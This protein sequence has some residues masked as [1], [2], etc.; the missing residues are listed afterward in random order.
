MKERILQTLSDLRKYA[1]DKGYEVIAFL[2][3]RRQLPDAFRQLV[4]L[5]EHQRAFDP[6]G[7]HRLFR[8]ETRQL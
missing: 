2:P 1:L 7:D 8:Q 3:R 6:P 4:H 5:S